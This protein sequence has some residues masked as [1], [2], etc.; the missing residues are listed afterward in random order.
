MA[1]LAYSPVLHLVESHVAVYKIYVLKN[2]FTDKVFYVGQTLQDNQSRLAGHLTQKEGS[3]MPKNEYIQ[4][5]LKQG[6][7]PIIETIETIQGTCYI[8]KMMTNERER[9][10]I[11]FYKESG[12]K[13]LNAALTGPNEKCHEYHTYLSS[14]KKGEGQYNFYYCGK[15]AGGASVY[16]EKRMIADG[17]RLPH[18]HELVTL[19]QDDYQSDEYNPWENE[20]FIKSIGYRKRFDSEY[21]YVPCY[22]DTDPNY[23]DDD[24]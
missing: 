18:E 8:D 10:W 6:S 21:C 16:D 15:T 3:N 17:F 12:C 2:P 5:I 11:R 9:Y 4:N 22:K 19:K 20:R 14:I 23:Y 13:L 7:K 1:M 24:Y